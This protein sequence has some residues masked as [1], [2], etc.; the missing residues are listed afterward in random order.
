MPEACP[1]YRPRK[2]HLTPHYKCVQDHFE[3][4]EQLWPERFEKHFGFWR[5]YL[6]EVML[7]Y[8]ACGDLPD[9]QVAALLNQRGLKTGADQA[10]TPASIHWIRYRTGL[11]SYKQRLR[12]AGMVTTQQIAKQLGVSDPTVKA[13]RRKGLL[14]GYE[15]DDNG[16]WLYR[17]PS[18]HLILKNTRKKRLAQQP[19]HMASSEATA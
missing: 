18:E 19:I 16:Q 9:G 8:L 10:F 7:R 13:W 3:T 15:C 17:P 11:K 5:P 12:Q 1:V 6:K 2:P 4:L 14:Q